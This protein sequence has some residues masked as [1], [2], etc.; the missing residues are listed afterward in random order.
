MWSKHSV[1]GSYSCTAHLSVQLT[2]LWWNNYV[3]SMMVCCFKS[4]IADDLLFCLLW[5]KKVQRMCNQ[6]EQTLGPSGRK[7]DVPDFLQQPDCNIWRGRTSVSWKQKVNPKFSL[8]RLLIWAVKCFFCVC[9]RSLG[10]PWT[11]AQRRIWPFLLHTWSC[12]R[13]A[14]FGNFKHLHLLHSDSS[15]AYWLELG[16]L[17]DWIYSIWIRWPFLL[18]LFALKTINHFKK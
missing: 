10:C 7:S 16:F 18:Y 4:A 17:P 14:K 8:C 3:E 5:L 6:Y 12:D 13:F 11:A 15:T 2:S 9:Q 1:I